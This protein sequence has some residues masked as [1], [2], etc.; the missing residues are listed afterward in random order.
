MDFPNSAKVATLFAAFLAAQLVL[1]SLGIFTFFDMW[2]CET[3]GVALDGWMDS[4]SFVTGTRWGWFSR[5]VNDYTGC[6]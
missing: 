6:I 4:M 3:Y 2:I 5:H 1:G